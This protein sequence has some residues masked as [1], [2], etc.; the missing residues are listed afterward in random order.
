[1]TKQN[2]SL[3]A[4]LGAAVV[5]ALLVAAPIRFGSRLFAQDTPDA[6]NP[7]YIPVVQNLPIVEEEPPFEAEVPFP[8]PPESE[9]PRSTDA[10]FIFADGFETNGLMPWSARVLDGS[11]LSAADAARIQGPAGMSATINDAKLINVIDHKP[12][13]EPRL[14]TRFYFDPN[15]IAMASGDF[16]VIYAAY[17][18]GDRM[19]ARIEF[20]F[21]GGYHL[22][23]GILN[24]SNR[25][26]NSS[27][28]ALSDG[29]H[30]IEIDWIKSATN[31]SINGALGLW[32]DESAV[33]TLKNVNNDQLSVERSRLGVISAPSAGTRGTL[34]F[35]QFET[36]RTTYIGP[37]LPPG[38]GT[39]IPSATPT[40]GTPGTPAP[41]PTPSITPT[42]VQ[43]SVPLVFVSRQIPNAGTIYWSVPSDLPGVGP[44][45]RFRNASPG[46]LQVRETNGAIRTLV[47][48]AN[49]T[50]ASLNLIDV[51]AP[52]VSYDATTIVF[53]G[54]PA[55]NHSRS[56]TS[57]PGAWRI[58]SIRVDGS[59]LRQITAGQSLNYSRFGS[60]A[61]QLQPYDDADPAWMPDGRI[62]FSST[63]YPS[64]AQYSGVRTSNLFVVNADGSALHRITTE[65]NG[66][67]RPAIDPITGKI[68]YARW[69]RNHRFALNSMDTVANGSG[70]YSQNL[71]LT[72][73]RGN[74]VGGGD[75]LWR[76][77]WHPAAINP[78]G[79]DLEQ[80]GGSHHKLDASHAYGGSFLP[81]GDLV[82]NYYPMANMTEAGGF[83]GIRLFRRGP[84]PYQSIIGITNLTLDY[85][86]KTNPTSYGVFVGNYATDASAL[87][88]GRLVV[89]W[90]RDVGQ[91]YGLYTINANGSGLTLLHDNPGTTEL[92]AKPIMTR[93]LP[94]ILPDSV[95]Q[96]VSALPPTASG[97]LSQDGV[98]TFDALNVYANG[99]VDTEIS[100]A[101]P[102]G[103]AQTIRFFTDFQRTSGGSFPN[104][105][106]PILLAQMNVAPDGSVRKTD[107][108]ANLPLFEQMRSA[109]GTV[110]FN[111]G[112]TGGA[113]HVAGMNFGK[114][115]EVQR[116]VGCHAGH[117]MI[118]VP[119]NDADAR[120]S[121][122]A[123]S[124]SVSVSSARDN[125][126]IRGVVDRRVMTGDIWRYWTSASGQNSG[127]WVQLTFP[128]PVTVRSVRLYNPR[129]G[130]EANS[131]LQVQGTSV[132][133]YS[134]TGATQQVALQ[135]TGA[136]TVG[137]TTISFAD[138][139]ARSVRVYITGMSGT[140]YGSQV[141]SVAEVEVIARA[142]AP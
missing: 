132:R 43:G 38:T 51:S 9:D 108:P 2:R 41:T 53:A 93:P 36:R 90:A 63:R 67:D 14:R 88:D 92:R 139:R 71:G 78:D 65:R 4:A 59:A 95:S 141:A 124:A 26:I 31:T 72:T 22:R 29:P 34:Y 33:A 19:L 105:D 87:P 18:S 119:A 24:D 50:A 82:A 12:T 115:G 30:L 39:P 69:W 80:W 134:D 84:L 94:P 125:N 116:C 101:L 35:D 81:N 142:E 60:A 32:I 62:V 85:V 16:L 114:P 75:F 136:L 126:Y 96:V 8:E 129:T 54:L 128:V 7:V 123:P 117:T 42:P 28:F 70:G 37:A 25:W 1:M 77:Q 133:L 61:G 55:G 64:F 5:L 13:N 113:A 15:S 10:E 102:V 47:D 52:D 111:P 122:I 23:A 76:N 103:S 104:L 56:T 110:P 49:P 118:A 74:H 6:A 137:G 46:K 3:L 45:S 21:A 100:N 98:F 97:D 48:G 20:G 131:S 11:D 73:D 66:A 106:W 44:H 107:V 68:V 57:N 127:Q 120:F 130:G 27:P 91:D 138:V 17:S 99:P 112:S 83:G 58:Y 140:F 109:D 40:Q 86:N 79:T 121:N 89:S 135:T